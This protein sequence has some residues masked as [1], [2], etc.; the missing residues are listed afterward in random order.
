MIKVGE[1]SV[2]KYIFFLKIWQV[3]YVDKIIFEEKKK[4]D[5]NFIFVVIDNK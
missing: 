5:Q 3:G 4:Y 1:S 2:I